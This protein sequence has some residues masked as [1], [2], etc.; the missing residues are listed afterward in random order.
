MELTLFVIVGSIAVISAAMMLIS[1]NAVHSALFL[2]LNFACI[3]FFFLMLRA[4]F[5]AMVQVA[6]YAGAIM[7]LFLFVIMLLGADRM[8]PGRDTRVPW[9]TPVAMLLAFVFLGTTTA[10][11][12][13]GDI[14][15]LDS[16]GIA[17]QVRVIHVLDG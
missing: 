15:F 9:L 3:A 1:D 8:V 6:V 5:L 14:D 10:T 12:L 11:V 7:V 2:I 17:P 13:N 16:K 4:P